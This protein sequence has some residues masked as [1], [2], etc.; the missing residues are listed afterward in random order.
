VK[1]TPPQTGL[2]V[3]E[4]LPELMAALAAGVSAV[5]VAPPGAGKTTLAPLWLA[6]ERWASGRILMLEPRRVAARAAAER[7]ASLL[8]EKPGGR[9]GYR[10]RGE[11]VAGS[12]IEVVT[13]GILTRMLQSDPSLAG[14]SAVIFDEFHERSLH[15]DLGL[16][17]TLEAQ[18]ALREDLR[19]LVMS[20]TLDAAAVAALMGGAPVV[21][22]EGRMYPVETRWLERPW[23]APGARGP[24]FED[25]M[26]ELIEAAMAEAPGDA[27]AFL[28]GAGEIRRVEAK[29]G[30][31]EGV[32]IRPIYGALPFARQR[33]AL[34]PSAKRKLVLATA[35]AETS[36]TIDGVRIVIDG[37]RARRA[38]FDPGSGMSRLVTTPVTRAEAEQR[39][40]RAG[41]T[42]P[43]VCYRLWTRGEEGALAAAPAPEI[44][45]ADLT[46]LALELAIWGSAD[47]AGLAFLDPPP[48]A[49]L[50]EA[51]ALLAGLGALDADGRVTMHGRALAATPLHPRLGHMVLT[52]EDPAGA[53]DVAAL[54]EERDLLGPGAP[55]DMALRVEA[56]RRPGAHAVDA[57]ARERVKENAARLRKRLKAAKGTEALGAM[58]ARAFPDR[59]AMRRPGEAPRFLMSGGKGAYLAEDDPLAQSRFLVAADLDGDLREA[60][61]R[62]AA[63]ITLSEIEGLFADAI[64]EVEVCEWSRRDR[65]VRAR[66]RMLGAL[67]LEDRIWKGAPEA[68]VTAAMLEGV[69]DLGLQALDWTP[70]AARLR[71]RGV[72]ARAE[73]ADL[74]DWSDDGLLATLEVWLA[75]ALRAVKSAAALKQVD[76]AAAL[77][78]SLDWE[79]AQALDRLAPAAFVTPAGGKAPVD[80]G[81][82]QP[83]ASVRLQEMFGL[84]VHPTIGPKRTPLL[85]DLLSPA[86]RPVQSTADLPGFWRS[87]YSDVRKDMRGRYPKHDWPE[88]PQ[89]ATP[90]SRPPRRR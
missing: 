14:V 3:E 83:A 38:R 32:E 20:A 82:A 68:T 86:G 62:L 59:V 17:L 44:A 61:I 18:G 65:A 89:D 2:P 48:P 45:E 13:E 72:W 27:L 66:R 16:A 40:G 64:R 81:R 9:V 22:S 75:P 10:I 53:A 21:R 24:R 71:A 70:A 74:P 4:A 51:R 58:L 57:G 12:R 23:R 7:M 42:A 19:V 85:L 37:G 77:R 31:L 79:A 87:S 54:L 41:R 8:G 60:R 46:G 67:A 73:G 56:L 15:A 78:G 25:A 80:Y 49:A 28:P 55:A 35:I 88:A 76:V 6:A 47:G 50:T 84:D 43:G 36:L 39:R 69:R 34:A 1:I 52:S 30:R 33:L 26:A 90:S 29:L 5:L 63:P 11:A